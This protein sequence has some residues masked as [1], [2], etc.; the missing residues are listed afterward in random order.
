[1][2]DELR[3]SDKTPQKKSIPETQSKKEIVP[4]MLKML[5]S[6]NYNH[7]LLCLKL[8]SEFRYP[9][10]LRMYHCFPIFSVCSVFIGSS[11]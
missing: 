9:G 8:D 7:F 6:V 11:Q 1:M 2:P 4:V 3:F 5:L 10:N